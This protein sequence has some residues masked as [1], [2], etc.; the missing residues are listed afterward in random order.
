[1]TKIGLL[2]ALMLVS[3]FAGAQ[4]Q[5][6]AASPE[7]TAQALTE[8]TRTDAKSADASPSAAK[9]VPPEPIAPAPQWWE[10]SD[11]LLV[12]PTWLLALVALGFTI[13]TARLWRAT[14]A[15]LS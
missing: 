3:T 2:A 9:A 11:W 4:L 12:I 15:L 8:P 7:P 6:P 5:P 10:R 13:Y 1:M 14:A